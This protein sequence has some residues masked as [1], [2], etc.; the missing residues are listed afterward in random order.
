MK[1]VADT[2]IKSASEPKTEER[3]MTRLRLFSSGWLNSVELLGNLET[4][5]RGIEDPLASIPSVVIY[6]AGRDV[7]RVRR[8]II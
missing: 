8:R 4:I 7:G 5:C 1:T 3:T 6:L 2:T